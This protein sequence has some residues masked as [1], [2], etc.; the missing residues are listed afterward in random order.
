MPSE[1]ESPDKRIECARVPRPTHKVRCTFIAAHSQRSAAGRAKM[2]YEKLGVAILFLLWGHSAWSETLMCKVQDAFQLTE[3]GALESSD[4]LKKMH[5]EAFYV[6]VETGKITGGPMDTTHWGETKVYPILE[7]KSF[8]VVSFTHGQDA[9][10][11]LRSMYVGE[12]LKSGQHA[13][14]IA[15]GLFVYVGVCK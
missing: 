10:R 4:S 5:P 12:R 15:D 9:N 3:K 14:Q 13:F 11:G 1:T 6:D 7:Y 8:T 2:S